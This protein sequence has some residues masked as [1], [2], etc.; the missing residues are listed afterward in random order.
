[1][2][3]DNGGTTTW[4]LGNFEVKH[5]QEG[6]IE[7]RHYLNGA[8]GAIGIHTRTY[9]QQAG[10]GSRTRYW[11]KDHLGSVTAIADEQGNAVQRSGFSGG[12]VLPFVWRETRYRQHQWRTTGE[13]L[14]QQWCR[15]RTGRLDARAENSN[16]IAGHHQQRSSNSVNYNRHAWSTSPESAIGGRSIDSA[17]TAAGKSAS[18]SDCV[19][20]SGITTHFSN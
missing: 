11:I 8:E 19:A 2:V 12:A 15:Q 18:T 16:I 1:V 13:R 6:G 4:Y 3:T 5:S 17:L 10:T 14:Y 7:E 20:P 9:G